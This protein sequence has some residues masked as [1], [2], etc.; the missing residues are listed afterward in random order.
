M[1]K[2]FLYPIS[3]PAF[4]SL[5]LLQELKEKMQSRKQLHAQF[6]SLYKT[7]LFHV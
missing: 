4:A 1:D 6:I 2:V 7:A 3:V 5:M